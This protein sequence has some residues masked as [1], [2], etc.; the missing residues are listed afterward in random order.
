MVWMSIS[1]LDLCWMG[2]HFNRALGTRL[3]VI[4]PEKAVYRYALASERIAREIK[5]VFVGTPFACDPPDK[6]NGS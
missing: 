4:L 1:G 2:L 6:P 3:G 5:H